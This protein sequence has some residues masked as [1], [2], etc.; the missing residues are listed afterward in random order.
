MPQVEIGNLEVYYERRGAGTPLVLVNGALDT[1]ESDWG[2]H[3]TSFAARH[4]V[5]AY[6]HRGHGRSQNPLGEFGGYEQLADDL[7]GLVNTQGIGQASFC[8]FSD[9]AITLVYF[10][11]RHPERVRALILAGAQQYNDERALAT[12]A[13]MT[14]ERISE[15]LP[16]WAAELEQLHD[17]HHRPGYWQDL[18]RQMRPMWQEWLGISVEMLHAVDMPT[19]L[20][21]G[22]RD[23]FG[24]P[25]QQLNMRQALPNAELCIA[26]RAGHN[27]MNDA[28]A[29]FDLV[30]GEFLARVSEDPRP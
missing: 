30:V 7:L 4:D 1:I 10:A 13:K 11:L 29:L 21:A 3:L 20:I 27:V 23:G 18:L 17:T 12:L 15:R 5:L 22:E 28:P 26:P 6:D 8:G 9:G 19:L 14:P 2:R 25:A 16:A 24:H